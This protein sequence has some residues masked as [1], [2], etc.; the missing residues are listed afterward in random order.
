MS[1]EKHLNLHAD[2]SQ[3]PL[4]FGGLRVKPAMTTFIKLEIRNVHQN[5]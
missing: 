3:H 4:R 5:T 2:E 1:T